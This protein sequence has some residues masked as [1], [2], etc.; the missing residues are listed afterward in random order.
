MP[1]QTILYH[2]GY[3]FPEHAD[4]V[5]ARFAQVRVVL[6]CGTFSRATKLAS[7][8]ST[9]KHHNLSNTD[10]YLLLSPIPTVLIA[11]HGIGL[12][13]ID[14]LLHDIYH[15]L[16][17]AGAT[18]W[19]F[20]R[21]GSSG[22]IGVHPGTIVITEQPLNGTLKPHLEVTVLGQKRYLPARLDATLTNQLYSYVSAE[23]G[24]NVVLGK[25]LCAETFFDSQARTDG[26]DILYTP[27]E[28]KAF[29]QSCAEIGI[30]NIE[31]ESIP[32]AA[33]AT[34]IG[35][36]AAVACVAFVDRLQHDTPVVSPDILAQLEN[37]AIETVANF[38]VH[39]LHSCIKPKANGASI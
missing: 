39:F 30:R 9:D 12:G 1:S 20:V 25:T 21:L 8:F 37:K 4:P 32:L 28:A 34:R 22:G 14:S 2:L 18:Q 13:S 15:L 3:R 38:V 5:T 10:R 31:M 29:L 33:F 19:C 27:D 36:P 11:S 6:L 35:I 16:R 23:Q 7:R 26:A 24:V 17:T